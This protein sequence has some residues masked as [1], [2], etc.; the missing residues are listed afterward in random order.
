MQGDRQ[1]GP[2]AG[3]QD[4]AADEQHGCAAARQDGELDGGPDE[5]Q[6]EYQPAARNAI[7]Q[8]ADRDRAQAEQ[9]E[10]A[11]ADETERYRR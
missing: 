2:F 3:S 9:E 4:D 1:R 6:R 10:E 7:G 5:R 8:E 11:A